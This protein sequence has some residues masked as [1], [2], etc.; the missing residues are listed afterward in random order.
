MD[1]VGN[2]GVTWPPNIQLTAWTD[3]TAWDTTM[4]VNK[5]Q[6]NNNNAMQNSK[7]QLKTGNTM[8]RVTVI[9][10]WKELLC[11][12]CDWHFNAAGWQ[13]VTGGTAESFQN[14]I[15]GFCDVSIKVRMKVAISLYEYDTPHCPGHF[16]VCTEMQKAISTAQ[17]QRWPLKK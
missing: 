10:Q 4:Q 7:M 1:G 17:M 5:H 16:S 12:S 13:G 6:T 9:V 8:R 3:R 11:N 14:F 2:T 15:F